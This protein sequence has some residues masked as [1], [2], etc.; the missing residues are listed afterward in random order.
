[1]EL[2]HHKYDPGTSHCFSGECSGICLYSKPCQV[3][4]S[5]G[6]GSGTGM[7]ERDPSWMSN[8]DNSQS[9]LVG[10][11]PQD[12]LVPSHLLWAGTRFTRASSSELNIPS[13]NSNTFQ[14]T[15]NRSLPFLW[16]LPTKC[17]SCKEE[18]IRRRWV[19]V[20]CQQFIRL[21]TNRE[22]L[23][24]Q[25]NEVN[26]RSVSVWKVLKDSLEKQDCSKL[27]VRLQIRDWNWAGVIHHA[28]RATG[29]HT[30][31]K[32]TLESVRCGHVWLELMFLIFVLDYC[33]FS[34]S[35]HTVFYLCD[36]CHHTNKSNNFFF[37]LMLSKLHSTLHWE[38]RVPN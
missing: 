9:S 10:R 38:H 26:P 33:C 35:G 1:M 14:P 29:R 5:E 27:R 34:F 25:K 11:D 4:V 30:E 13:F 22:I 12:Y 16:H 32:F 19:A 8:T 15:S 18:H 20:V 31:K 2:S 37:C 36:F 3:P 21:K 23:Q 6:A 24:F 7:R 17:Q 28:D